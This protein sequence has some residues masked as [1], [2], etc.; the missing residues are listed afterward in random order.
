MRPLGSPP[1]ETEPPGATPRV[2]SP[3]GVSSVRQP[4]RASRPSR[5]AHEMVRIGSNRPLRGAGPRRVTGGRRERVHQLERPLE[6]LPGIRVG[7]RDPWIEVE[8]EEE[9]GQP[10]VAVAL[11]VFADLL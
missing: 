11:D 2:P 3:R 9:L 7:R 5:P 8:L 1:R 4:Y 6:R 10:G